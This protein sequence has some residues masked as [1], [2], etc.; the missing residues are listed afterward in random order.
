MSAGGDRDALRAAIEAAS[1]EAV[2]S[3]DLNGTVTS[4]NAAAE[5]LFGYRATEMIGQSVRRLLPP[6]RIDEEFAILARVGRGE[7]LT[8]FE[9]IRVTKAG[10]EI[11]VSL[12]FTP[13]RDATG[14]IVGISK[15]ARDQT[16]TERAALESRR[17]EGLLRS[18][19]DTVPDGMVVIDQLGIVRFVSVAA[20]R[21]FGYTA[22]EIAGRNVNLLM[23]SPHAESH[24][25]YIARYLATGEARIIGVGRIVAGRRRDGSTF[26]MELQIGETRSP[27]SRLFV[28]FVRDLTERQARDRRV[29]EL[30]AELIH[31]SRVSE[32]GQMVTALAHE[33]D[34]PLTAIA[35]YLSG[36]RRLLDDASPPR[37]HEAIER[38]T[39][40]TRRA[41][42]IVR[43]LRSLVRGEPGVSRPENLEAVIQEATALALVGRTA[44]PEFVS[45][46]APDAR[47]AVIDKVQIMQVLL[48][49]MRNAM[50]AMAAS[51]VRRMTVTAVRRDDRIEIA[52]SDTGPGL[53]PEVREKLFQPFV[54]TKAGGLGVGLSLCRT[55]VQGHGGD[56]TAED[57][58]GG[59]TVFRFS[60]PALA[61]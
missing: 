38:V 25:A 42:D 1:N 50:E 19:L 36:I 37:L 45:R 28:G 5:R 18:I 33:V 40:Q 30:Q 4:W 61:V 26:P 41:R 57:G 29:S 34:Q 16:E 49:L 6:D 60:V 17:R 14:T 9:T 20:E 31:V 47:L 10:K 46:I 56:L 54:T 44:V 23:P 13:I 24:N 52:M 8:R 2:I 7:R 58:E 32:L 43:G 53:A 59:G 27:E 12:S 35:N 55:I 11:P 48:N 15:T 51:P 39:E 22:E 21:M 3:K